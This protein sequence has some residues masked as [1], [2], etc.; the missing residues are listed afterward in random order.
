[1]LCM[2]DWSL[3]RYT[4]TTHF[5]SGTF[6]LPNLCHWF[7]SLCW[8]SDTASFSYTLVWREEMSWRNSSTSAT[9][10]GLRSIHWLKKSQA[11]SLSPPSCSMYWGKQVVCNQ[12]WNFRTLYEYPTR[13]DPLQ[14]GCRQNLHLANLAATCCPASTTPKISLHWVFNLLAFASWLGWEGSTGFVA[15]DDE[16]E[17]AVAAGTSSCPN[18]SCNSW[19]LARTLFTAASSHCR[20]MNALTSSSKSVTPSASLAISF[21]EEL[22]E[23]E[24]TSASE[25]ES[26][27]GLGSGW[28]DP[29]ETLNISSWISVR[30]LW[31]LPLLVGC[32]LPLHSLF[33]TVFR[34][35]LT[36]FKPNGSF[37][38][39]AV[40]LFFSAVKLSVWFA[41]AGKI[42]LT[43]HRDSIIS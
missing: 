26:E 32:F 35:F 2:L 31:P 4:H 42:C 22:L 12:A 9:L 29:E 38:C 14:I 1:M 15:N 7:V 6:H 16:L 3:K 33:E 11:C 20:T 18:D 30:V 40:L 10:F 25:S 19:W 36:G 17:A 8:C 5:G 43:N 21:V 23:E 13:A 24:Q 39:C 28:F 37:F 41:L 27:S 34:F